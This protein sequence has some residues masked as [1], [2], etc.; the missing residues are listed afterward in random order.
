M[1]G[2][3][4]HFWVRCHSNSPSPFPYHKHHQHRKASLAVR[5]GGGGDLP[6]SEQVITLKVQACDT[7]AGGGGVPPDY[8]TGH[9]PTVTAR[10][11]SPLLA[12]VLGGLLVAGCP[13]QLLSCISGGMPSVAASGPSMD[14][15]SQG[16]C[17]R[18]RWD[19]R[20]CG[21]HYWAQH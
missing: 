19:P 15:E 11:A 13:V 2:P 3:P 17:Q 10:P 9:A 1:K 5:G 21:R 7:H 8:L 12:E 4:P 18:A 14:P 6:G 16:Q 20:L